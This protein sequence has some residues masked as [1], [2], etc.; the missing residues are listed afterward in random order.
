MPDLPTADLSRHQEPFE[1]LDLRLRTI[2]PPAY[3]DSY[4]DVKPVSMGS[5]GLKFSQDG[6][7]AWDE[8]WGS[9]CDLAMA[10]GPPHKGTLLEPATPAALA[11]QPAPS[12]QVAQEICRGIRMVTYLAVEPFP[13]P[14]WIGVDCDTW[15]MAEWFLRAIVMEN[16][17]A[18]CEGTMLCLPVGPA[19]RL[20]KEIK[21][22]ITAVAKAFHYWDGHIPPSQKKTIAD[23]FRE[24]ASHSPL[25]QPAFLRHNSPDALD[26]TLHNQIAAAIHHATGL[27][28]SSHQYP[29]WLGI[30]CPDVSS[31]V[32]IMRA[33]VASNVLA[34]REATVLFVPVNKM[35]DPEGERTVQAVH[36]IHRFATEVGILPKNASPTELQGFH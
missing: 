27:G 33:L 19:Y 7:V 10:G 12:R 32:W 31:A 15:G 17:S 23:L 9:F 22:V 5:A 26:C 14:G 16:V 4:E 18:R 34:R 30:E 36:R 21:N 25:I 3:Q 29:G 1:A 24:M 6:K 2:L 28:H 13:A 11:A 8:I 35:L 20:E